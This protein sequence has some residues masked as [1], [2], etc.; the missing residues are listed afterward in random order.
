MEQQVAEA[1][2][3]M[4][5]PDT[6]AKTRAAASA[7]LDHFTRTSEAWDIYAMW[8]RSF[9]VQADAETMGMQLLCLQ[10]LQ[11]K[12]RREVPRGTVNGAA[13]V[14]S[15]HQIQ[16]E[17]G[18]FLQQGP[19]TAAGASSACTCLAAL[20]VRRGGLQDLI[21]LCQS[22][23]TLSPSISLSLLAVIPL[24]VEACSDLS[25]PQVT[26]E[27]WP[28]LETTINFIRRVLTDDSAEGLLPALE[29]LKHWASTCHI[30]LT[31]L[32][33]PTCGGTESLLPVLVHLLSQP[34][35]VS[36]EA[37]LVQAS[38]ALTEAV[39]VPSDSCSE[40]R[41]A[42][43]QMMFSAIASQGFIVNPLRQ[44]SE[45]EWED[46]CHALAT[47]ICTLVSEEV[48]DVVGH[49]ADP[50]LHLL[51]HIQNHP[52]PKTRMLALD[53]WLTVQEVPTSQRH[54]NWKAP[55]FRQ[56][57][58]GL[59]TSTAFPA[60]FRDWEQEVDLDQSE[61]EEFRTMVQDVYVSA[62][63]LL[64]A[65][66]VQHL[67]TQIVS[68]ADWTVQEAALFA[69]CAVSREVCARCKAQG[70][71]TSISKDRERTAELLLQLVQHLVSTDPSTS[72]H[73]LV[74]AGIVQFIGAYAPAW[75]TKC[76]PEA[77]LQLLT[78]LR[79]SLVASPA[80]AEDTASAIRSVLVGCCNTLL[81][82]PA[83]QGP[84]LQ[85][86]REIVDTVLSIDKGEAMATVAVGYTRLLV[87]MKD[88]V[89][90]RQMLANLVGPLL[91]HGEIALN[92]IP[93]D[94]SL[95]S[96]ESVL[97]V[98]SLARYLDALQKI[99]RFCD[100][101]S[102]GVNPLSEIMTELWPFL[103]KASS[104]AAHFEVV[105][106][107][108]LAIHEQLLKNLPDL[109]SP[110][111]QQTIKY[112][113]D[114]FDRTKN[115]SALGYINSA[116][117]GSGSSNVESF[118]ELLAHISSSIFTYISSE[119]HVHECTDLIRAFF[120][121]NQRYILYCPAAL[122][123]CPQF[124]STVSCAVECL[125]ACQ[126]ER[127][128]TRATFNFLGQLFGWR[129]LRLSGESLNTFQTASHLVDEQIALHGA[130]IAQTCMATLLGGP[131]MLWPS[132]T[133]CLFAV[134]TSTVSWVVP[135]DPA[136]NMAQQWM[137]Q[138][139]P[140]SSQPEVYHQ[141]VGILLGLARDGPK[142]KPKAKMLLTD[143]CKICKGE[144]TVDALV[145]YS[146]P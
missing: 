87:Q 4:I 146:L 130:R 78:Y 127:E 57:A 108:V 30:S 68:S 141:V 129:A 26:A 131:Q 55:L 32:N 66:F 112:V 9:S 116:V 94:G 114:A 133:D 136:S 76:A 61:F 103:E 2:K 31:I 5:R 83:A 33:T 117:E 138:A 65:D 7:F 12:I 14:S 43:C 64:R 27:L 42:A 100:T 119:K 104:R 125:T 58:E 140:G 85:S 50:L 15:L 20:A 53:C 98:E 75:A 102:S 10:L 81:Q 70:G 49:S 22:T 86:Q 121:L 120:E 143:Y 47:L 82:D 38:L 6:D 69:F 122:I 17:L 34:H 142:N 77:I 18:N 93:A 63:F 96:P 25:T 118:R 144:M 35:S 132:S 37:V 62:Y 24:E 59:L 67:V 39:M 19:K 137:Y 126:G 44:A 97:A 106:S 3:A 128:S 99:V 73:G 46:A 16:T 45:Q 56:V 8:L 111:F 23:T 60:N 88:E 109:V 80:A 91:Q 95:S 135:E 115:A 74:L 92:T 48:D 36:N 105:L 40:G 124:A 72:K 21:Q 123:S 11:G 134:V 54:D 90:R 84:L 107:K 71:G 13:N 51:L 79:A 139:N 1:A 89:P 113:V 110:H 52:L 145:S 101:G 28:F 29:T 41:T